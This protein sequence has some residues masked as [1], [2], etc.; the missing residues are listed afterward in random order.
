MKRLAELGEDRLINR[1][2]ELLGS[3]Q[4]GDDAAVL[5]GF[6]ERDLLLASDALIEGVHFLS[7]TLPE[8]IGHK[9]IARVMSDVA[10]MGGSPSAFL[11]NLTAPADFPVE[12]VE[13]IYRGMQPLLEETGSEIV[14]GDS[15]QSASLALHVFGMGEVPHGQAV[16]RS[17]A[18]AGQ[19]ILVTGLL[20][21]SFASGRHLNF[22]PR[23]KVGQWLRREQF[24]TAMI[25]LS[26]GLGTDLP[27][28]LRA[29]G[30]GAAISIEKIPC[31]TTP[32]SAWRDGEDFELCFTVQRERLGDLQASWPFSDLPLTRIGETRSKPGL[33]D[34]EG[35]PLDLPE[36]GSGYTHFRIP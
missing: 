15:S 34:E 10:A 23:I 9:A 27:R 33:V 4:I 24:A 21:D 30:C 6:G 2:K 1:L 31:H 32:A 11:I 3:Q 19:G 26:D 13:A 35:S 5:S 20:G 18:E 36:G 28:L 25:D 17:G 8:S 14:G 7:G 29:S 12:T 22:Q 16:L